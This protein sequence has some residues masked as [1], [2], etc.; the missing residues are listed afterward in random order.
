MNKKYYYML[1][2]PASGKTTFLAAFTYMLKNRTKNVFLHLKP[3]ELPEGVDEEFNEQ[4][5]RWA[6][7]IK[8]N[9]TMVGQ[10]HKMKYTL[11]GDDD[12]VYVLDVPDRSGETFFQILKDRYASEEIKADLLRTSEFLF[13]VNLGEMVIGNGEEF[14]EEISQEVRAE[15][16]LKEA[17]VETEKKN[18]SQNESGEMKSGQFQMV[19]LLQII[20]DI[21][22]KRI[23]IKFIISAWDQH[24]KSG[25]GGETPLPESVFEKKL[26]LVYQFLC[27]NEEFY[28][29]QYWGV[30][31]QGGE[32]S[33]EKDNLK[34]SF[35]IEAMERVKVVDASGKVNYDLSRIFLE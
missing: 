9:H 31:A 30:S 20:S 17:D 22:N 32:L 34:K 13:F 18:E 35:N 16:E 10:V 29:V 23:I 1:G 14:L 28:D 11:Y 21:C 5:G 27:S 6:S 24:E 3:D 7:F 8:L 4:I 19:D 2:F 33:D 26:P 25:E 15:F 12:A